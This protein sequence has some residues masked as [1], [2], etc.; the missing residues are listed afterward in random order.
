MLQA[1]GKLAAL[2]AATIAVA[3]NTAQV[4]HSVLQ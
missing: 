4:W 2:G 3:C 1:M